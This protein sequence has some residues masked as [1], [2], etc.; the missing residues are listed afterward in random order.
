[1]APKKS[2]QT[3]NIVQPFVDIR[4]AFIQLKIVPE[5]ALDK[6]HIQWLL[7][8]PPNP[9]QPSDNNFDTD[10]DTDTDASD[11]D[12]VE[13]DDEEEETRDAAAATMTGSAASSSTTTK[14]KSISD[15]VD[16][17]DDTKIVIANHSIPHLNP[18]HSITNAQTRKLEHNLDN[19]HEHEHED[20][21]EH[22]LSD[23]DSDPDSDP[24]VG[25]SDQDE[26]QSRSPP[27]APITT[28]PCGLSNYSNVVGIQAGFTKNGLLTAL[29]ICI[30]T[31]ALLITDIVRKKRSPSPSSSSRAPKPYAR[32]L[33]NA[34]FL[35]PSSGDVRVLTFDGPALAVGLYRG[36]GFRCSHIVDILSLDR[37]DRAPL[38][39]IKA[40][41]LSDGGINKHNPNTTN[42]DPDNSDDSDEDDD[43]EVVLL[44]STIIREFETTPF[45][46]QFNNAGSGLACK[47]WL[48]WYIGQFPKAQIKLREIKPIDTSIHMKEEM[49]ILGESVE[50]HLVL[51]LAKDTKREISLTSDNSLSYNNNSISF[52]QKN[53]NQRITAGARR[54]DLQLQTATL[55]ATIRN[56]KGQKANLRVDDLEN[57]SNPKVRGITVH[58]KAAAT[59]AERERWL[60]ALDVLQGNKTLF[61]NKWMKCLF[62]RLSKA[63][64]GD[65]KEEQQQEE[66]EKA[67]GND[68]DVDNNDND[69]EVSD[70]ASLDAGVGTFGDDSPMI[71]T[72]DDTDAETVSSS[73]ASSGRFEGLPRWG[74][75]NYN[76][77]KNMWSEGCS[78]K[79]RWEHDKFEGDNE[80][81]FRTRSNSPRSRINTKTK[82]TMEFQTQPSPKPEIK[83]NFSQDLNPSQHAAVT[84]MLD[85]N[86]PVTIVKGPPGTG[87]T[88][89]IAAFI[90]SL[91]RQPSSPSSPAKTIWVVAQ[92]N[93]G[94]KNIAD[95]LYKMNIPDWVL[96][97]NSEFYQGWHAHLYQNLP[98][99]RYIVSSDFRSRSSASS[100]NSNSNS[101]RNPNSKFGSKYNTRSTPTPNN[102]PIG[103][104]RVVLCTLSMLSNPNIA[105]FKKR[106][107]MRVL[108]VDEASQIPMTSYTNVINGISGAGAGAGLGPGSWS[109]AGAGYGSGVGS[110][111]TET[112]AGEDVLEKMVFI[113]DDRQLPPFASDQNESLDSVFENK[114]LMK[115][116]KVQLLDVQYRMP[117]A[118]GDFLSKNVYSGLLNSWEGHPVQKDDSL[119]VQFVDVKDSKEEVFKKSYFNVAEANAVLA[120]IDILYRK[121]KKYKVITPYEAQ[122]DYIEDELRKKSSNGGD[123]LSWK[124]TVFT[125]DS[126]QGNEE[127]YIIISLT[128]TQQLGFLNDIRRSNVMLSR[129][130]E[131]MYIVTN[132]GFF[133]HPLMKVV[134]TPPPSSSSPSHPL[135]SSHPL[136]SSHPLI[137]PSPPLASSAS[138]SSESSSSASTTT[139]TT[140]IFSPVSA[141]STL[142]TSCDSCG[143]RTEDESGCE[144]GVVEESWGLSTRS[145]QSPQSIRSIREDK[146]KGSKELKGSK[147]VSPGPDWSL[148]DEE[149]DQDQ[150]W[151]REKR[152]AKEVDSPK[153]LV[154]AW[155]KSPNTNSDSSKPLGAFKEDEDVEREEGEE[156]LEGE[157]RTSDENDHD[158]NTTDYD[159]YDNLR[160]TWGQDNKTTDRSK[161]YLHIPRGIRVPGRNRGQ[162]WA[163][164][165]SSPG[166]DQDQDQ[167][168]DQDQDQSQGQ[169][170]GQRRGGRQGAIDKK[171]IKAF[172]RV[173]GTLV[174]KM[175]EE[176]GKVERG[177]IRFDLDRIGMRK[178][179]REKG[180]G[181]GRGWSRNE[182]G[183][184]YGPGWGDEG[185]GD[186]DEEVDDFERALNI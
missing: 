143:T 25:T 94:V 70:T 174:G 30:D 151:E 40:A 120:I 136:N 135:S 28:T 13:S 107:P 145:S 96:L 162:T 62:P 178:R 65:N 39:A 164:D 175:A 76:R 67:A 80:E 27:V 24:E 87:K 124:N 106:V 148:S 69:N 44:E 163:Q 89:A 137:T 29:A 31:K 144:C 79:D 77:K 182:D 16:D 15:E 86:K 142:L 138:T 170:Q 160:V 186:G 161:L 92:S 2:E 147:F 156:E 20:E 132:A 127:D 90:S 21:Y 6:E 63:E 152:K 113:G 53:Y 10:A 88:T 47:A 23:Q 5:I 50:A 98:S 32:D 34:L 129:A 158:E 169:G 108:V 116:V 154:K 14:G 117:P 49:D 18:L 146:I 131:G 122:R 171:Y 61:T 33:I 100:S 68:N 111:R 42:S 57:V 173:R 149:Q 155:L 118:I 133:F 81:P 46:S 157:D 58:G 1:M 64:E 139:P 134:Y 165:E 140:S 104:Q 3:I 109:G 150:D 36:L 26:I 121:Q 83:V 114:G 59:R 52:T 168:Q 54:Y 48:A 35:S 110:R 12:S 60:L 45:D 177:W 41:L 126:F 119:C 185:D 17:G 159:S 176:W 153:E 112:G 37:K 19:E 95:K 105:Q 84:D 72:P 99:S 8:K 75:R 115:S 93:V 179:A 180:R 74:G 183:S 101:K 11:Y 85:F 103:T 123:G 91:L 166:Q 55:P 66:G 51:D 128:R 78:G 125:V 9:Q 184:G 22:A 43:D 7:P 56:I 141:T 82:N 130:K 38:T 97:V 71:S 73:G 181:R 172:S 167:G 102:S 4:K